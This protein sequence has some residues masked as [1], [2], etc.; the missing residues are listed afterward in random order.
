MSL[1]SATGLVALTLLLAGCGGSSDEAAEVKPKTNNLLAI[2]QQ[3]ILDAESLQGMLD[4]DA[5]LKK[6]NI[7]GGGAE[8]M[9]R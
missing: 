5:E 8:L 4:K 1:S 7:I 9:P 2:E 3:L 6:K